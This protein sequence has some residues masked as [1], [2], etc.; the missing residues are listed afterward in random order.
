MCES[1][2][3]SWLIVTPRLSIDC[4]RACM[5]QSTGSGSREKKRIHLENA[6]HSGHRQVEQN[7]HSKAEIN[8]CFIPQQKC[9]TVINVLFFFTNFVQTLSNYYLQ[10]YWCDNDATCFE[11]ILK[12]KI[13]FC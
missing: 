2:R 4:A 12:L 8:H 11:H 9:T 10:M 3:R 5:F 13:K 7:S 6:I 1:N